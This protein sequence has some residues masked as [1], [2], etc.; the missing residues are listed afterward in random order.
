M[1]Q[2]NKV[3]WSLKLFFTRHKNLL[4]YLLWTSRSPEC[5]SKLPS[6][7]HFAGISVC[8]SD[9]SEQ[10]VVLG[11]LFILVV[12]CSAG[13]GA[14]SSSKCPTTACALLP[15]SAS[16]MLSLTVQSAP[17]TTVAIGNKHISMI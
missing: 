13:R 5:P 4:Q 12:L 6:A 3:N 8:G 16:T 14:A 11:E 2:Y 7:L 1:I 9:Y 17:Q 15:V 10:V